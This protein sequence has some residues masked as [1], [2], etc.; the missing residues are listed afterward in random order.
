MPAKKVLAEVDRDE[1]EP[2]SARGKVGKF[3][4]IGFDAT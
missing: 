2:L 1:A 4:G 3:V